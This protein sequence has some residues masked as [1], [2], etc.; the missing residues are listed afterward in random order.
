MSYRPRVRIAHVTDCYLPRTGGIE[1]QVRALANQQAARGDEVHI[2]TA[3]PLGGGESEVEDAG[4]AVHRVTMALPFDLPVHPRTRRRVTQLLADLSVD[5]VHIHTG[6]ISPFAWGGARAVRNMGIPALITVHSMWGPLARIGFFL[7]DLLL[8]WSSWGIR[9]SAVS[10]VASDRVQETLRSARCVMIVPNGI[11]PSLWK[12]EPG[13]RNGTVLGL[14]TVM[15]LAPRKRV[16][17]LLRII[18]SVADRGVQVHL[19]VVGDGPDLARA[20]R[21]VRTLGLS[22]Q[23]RFA[24]RCDRQA[25]CSIFADSDVFI[26]PSVKESF[27]LAALEA[28]SAG[29]PVVAR[30][31]T[32]TTGFIRD[33]REGL[34]AS[35]DAGMVAAI[36]RLAGDAR[37]LASIS[38]HNRQVPPAETWPSVL[39]SVDEGYARFE[40]D[41]EE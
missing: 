40:G 38:D 22:N 21:K 13:R 14:V 28:R 16:F 26:Q 11:D 27:G 20:Q 7:S 25:I 5:A 18:K 19:T 23:V 3:S 4:I 32:G 17:P 15:R 34:I 41:F 37:L 9:I 36:L 1:S 6:V 29:L 39:R 10:S 31:Q 24:G 2:I 12:V 30:A 35:D 33:G 8:H